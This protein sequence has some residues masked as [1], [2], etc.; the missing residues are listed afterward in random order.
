VNTLSDWL[1]ESGLSGADLR[2]LLAGLCHR[3]NP[4]GIAVE[5]GGCAVLRLHPQI[6]SEE[7]S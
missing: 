5:R 2:E 1:I 7:V 6:F 3:L 4:G